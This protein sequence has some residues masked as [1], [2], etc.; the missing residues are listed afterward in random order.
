MESNTIIT[1]GRAPLLGLCCALAA[2]LAPAD[3]ARATPGA[4]VTPRSIAIGVLPEAIRAKFKAA[5]DDERA[6]RD[7]RVVLDAG[8]VQP[9]HDESGTDVEDIVVIEFTIAPGG[10]FGWHKHGGPVWVVVKQGTL[11]LYDA[12]DETCTGTAYIAGSAFLDSGDHVHNARNEGTEPV[13]VYGTFMLP[14]GGAVRVDAPN[15]GV[16]PF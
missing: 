15:P 3:E 4:G 6:R 16:C 2:A 13:V 7:W 1:R 9:T 11:T 8:Q 14:D 12:D 10:Y 5:H